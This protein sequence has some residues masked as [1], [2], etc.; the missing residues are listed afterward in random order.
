MKTLLIATSN[1]HKV[2]EIRAVLAPLG[3]QILSLDALGHDLEEPEEDGA[4]FEANAQIKARYYANATGRVCLA[5]DSGLEVD[6]L[7]GAPGVLSARYA[8]T[9]RTRAERDEA[10]NLKLLKALHGVPDEK[11]QARFVCAMCVAS[12][13]GEI[14]AETRGEFPG[15]IGHEPK[16][17]NGFGYDPLLY[18]LDAR[19]TSAELPPDEKNAR[20]HRGQASRLMAAKLRELQAASVWPT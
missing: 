1:P 18:L 20:S 17:V 7:G 4:T 16:G 15:V 11:R 2:D 19:R 3:F 14:L 5:D 10:N 9:G 13:D 6:A 12:P 8:G